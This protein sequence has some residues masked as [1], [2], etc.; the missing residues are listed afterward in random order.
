MENKIIDIKSLSKSFHGQT[1][2][3]SI[4]LT[5]NNGEFLTILGPSGCGKTTLLKIISGLELADGGQLYFK[6]KDISDLPP[7]AREINTVFQSF[8]L[9]PHMTVF[10]NVA[11]GLKTKKIAKEVIQQRVE[12]ALKMVKLETLSK[13]KPSQLSGGQQQRVAIA[14]AVVNQPAILL[15][16]EP[17]SALDY[18]LRKNM[19]FELKS[20]QQQL[21]ITFILVTHDQEEALT[22]A[23]RIVV[24]KDGNIEQVGTPREIYEE[25]NNL[26][27]AKFV[28]QTNIFDVTVLEANET[29]L[30][31]SL[32]NTTLLLKNKR[33]F[34]KG[35]KAHLLLRPEDLH[36]WH[37]NEIEDTGM[38][39]PA[40]VEQFIYKGSTVD[41]ILR[42]NS[43]KKISATEFFDEDDETLEYEIGES[44]LV[45]LVPGWEVLLPHEE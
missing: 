2:L 22:M 31:V 16:D 42:L 27:I 14:R 17:L 28:G 8:A 34:K 3:N 43:G 24:M 25:P 39:I 37:L 7:Q 9:F 6:N 21:G 40:V 10:D 18:Q 4:D 41:L 45:E 13:R 23:D 11:F 12:A 19:Q 33:A 36:V 20:L 5:V 38:M 30:A 29:Q 1:V 32:E 35:E 44:V 26:Y 15:L